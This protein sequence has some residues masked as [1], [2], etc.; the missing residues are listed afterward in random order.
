MR[1]TG[2]SVL[3]LAACAAQPA[4]LGKDLKP[5]AATS[6]IVGGSGVDIESFPWQGSLQ[7]RGGHICGGASIA[8][9]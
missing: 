8:G 3:F 2:L 9:R 5:E 4:G 1:I 7:V 6:A